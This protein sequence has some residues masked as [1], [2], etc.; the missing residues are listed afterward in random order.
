M[1]DT[2]TTTPGQAVIWEYGKAPEAV[3]EIVSDTQG[4]ETTEKMVKY[5]RIGILYYAIHDPG[6][7]VQPEPLRVFV[8]RRG[9]MSRA[10]RGGCRS[11]GWG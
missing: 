5:A 2:G 8:L 10:R 6:L 3:V 11:W 4:G 7:I 9:R 1:A